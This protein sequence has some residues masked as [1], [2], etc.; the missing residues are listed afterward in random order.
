MPFFGPALG[1]LS[2]FVKKKLGIKIIFLIENYL[3]HEKRW[4][5]KVLA[6][7]ALKNADF[8][9]AWRDTVSPSFSAPSADF[10]Y[11]F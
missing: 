1:T 11:G 9:I 3:S 4:F 8:F 10:L 6:K 7:Y 5:N 2:S